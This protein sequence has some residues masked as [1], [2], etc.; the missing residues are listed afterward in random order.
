[1]LLLELDAHPKA[2]KGQLSSWYQQYHKAPEFTYWLVESIT[3]KSIAQQ[4]NGS[5][6]LKHGLE[7]KVEIELE[8]FDII[9]KS[10]LTITNWET[11][12]H[13]CQSLALNPPLL[14]R[15]AL[16]FQ[17]FLVQHAQHPKPFVR[18][19]SITALHELSKTFL[20]LKEDA[21]RLVQTAVNDPAKSVQARIRNLR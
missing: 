18:A 14:D 15:S 16:N 8:Q 6:L 12:L 13:L 17:P 1:M 21:V 4:R 10:C 11:I 19:W 20:I 9:S 3:S 7:R 5:W 2:S